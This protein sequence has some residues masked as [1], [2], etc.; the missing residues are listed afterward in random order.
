MAAVHGW[1]RDDD[2]RVRRLASESTRPRLPWSPR[3]NLPATAT[4]D[5]LTR[6]HADPSRYVTQSVANHLR[7]ITITDPDFVLATLTRWQTDARPHGK[8]LTF[9]SREALKTRLKEGWAP[10]YDFL[11]YATDGRVEIGAVQLERTTVHVGENLAFS[12]EV[13]ATASASLHVTYVITP[14][15]PGPVHREKVYFLSRATIRP[16]KTLALA[17]K[18][19]LRPTGTKAAKPGLFGL[20]IQVNGR[21]SSTSTFSVLESTD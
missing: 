15:P 1:A 19:P 4:A 14:H 9:I 7:D 10:A 13:T 16:G 8:D 21:R 20:Q 3:I 5:V 18:H 12:V 11:G 6:L 2:Y 17:K